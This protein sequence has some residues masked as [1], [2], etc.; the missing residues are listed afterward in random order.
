MYRYFNLNF[1]LSLTGRKIIK[2]GI[3]NKMSSSGSTLKRY[4]ILMS[5]IFIYCKIHKVII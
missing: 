1:I 3:L 4:C 2:E 5:D